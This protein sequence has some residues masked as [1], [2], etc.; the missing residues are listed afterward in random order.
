M[1]D[2]LKAYVEQRDRMF[3]DGDIDGLRKAMLRTAAILG[4]PQDFDDDLV[5]QVFHKTRYEATNISREKRIASGEWLRE[6]GFRRMTG[7]PLL[8]PN[9]LPS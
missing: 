6:R 9:Q 4:M 7:Q 1:T 8:A 5:R 2:D 3:E